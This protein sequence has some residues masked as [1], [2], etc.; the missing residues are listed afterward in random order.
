MSEEERKTVQAFGATVIWG[1]V[2]SDYDSPSELESRLDRNDRT[3]ALIHLDLDVLD[4]SL[5]KVNDFSCP[6][7]LEEDDLTG[8]MAVTASNVTPVTSTVASLDP[9]LGAGHQI[10][11]IAI[12]AIIHFI[13]ILTDKGAISVRRQNHGFATH[14]ESPQ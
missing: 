8:C 2:K 10:A 3:P 9:N 1:G 14:P 13:K 12:K 7:G 4:V 11:K 5:G 6:G